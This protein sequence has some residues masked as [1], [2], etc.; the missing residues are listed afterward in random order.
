MNAAG[1]C[2]HC[3][4]DCKGDGWAA[5]PPHHSVGGRA[6]WESGCC[7]ACGEATRIAAALDAEAERR[8]G[9]ADVARVLDPPAPVRAARAAGV[10]AG[11]EVAAG[12]ARG[13]HGS[14]T[15]L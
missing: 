6:E 9:Q 10:V 13:G 14:P 11:L 15:P 4:A 8:R 5:W 2:R 7:P 12:I 3:D 1:C